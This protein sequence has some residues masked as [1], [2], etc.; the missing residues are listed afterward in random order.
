MDANPEARFS[1]NEAHISVKVAHFKSAV[2]G[3]REIPRLLF[4]ACS[5]GQ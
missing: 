4:P 5:G 2:A 1:R 3:V